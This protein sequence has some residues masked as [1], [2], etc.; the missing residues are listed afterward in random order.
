MLTRRCSREVMYHL[1]WDWW[2]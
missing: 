1:W 2:G